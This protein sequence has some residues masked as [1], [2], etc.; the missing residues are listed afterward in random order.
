METEEND[1]A[2]EVDMHSV[3]H[4]ILSPSSFILSEWSLAPS[5]LR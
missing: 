3:S 5:F 4:F 1:G 2:A